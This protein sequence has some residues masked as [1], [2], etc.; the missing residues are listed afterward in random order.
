MNDYRFGNFVCF[1]REKKGMTQA[2]LAQ[3]LNVTPA[4]VSKW[5]NGSSKPRVEVLFQLAQILEVRPEE[6]IA[7]EYLEQTTL[8]PAVIEQI[9]ERYE[10]LRRI[11]SHNT[12]SVKIRRLF[13]AWIDWTLCGII[14]INF[15]AILISVFGVM[16]NEFTNSTP[17]VLF[18]LFVMLL[19][20]VSFVLRD[21]ILNGRSLG[22][23]LLKLSVLDRQ[24]GD[25]AKPSQRCCRNLLL[26]LLYVDAIVMLI[27][28]FT[29]GDRLAHTVVVSQ[30]DID[31]ARDD[32]G[33]AVCAEKI[34]QYSAPKPMSK[35]KI[36]LLLG[37]IALCF[38]MFIGFIFL[39]ANAALK[40]VRKTEEYQI[41]YTYLIES[42]TLEDMGV[43]KEQVKHVSYRLET[44]VLR[45]G[46]QHK[47]AEFG[48]DIGSKK[49]IYVVCH[50]EN[51][52]WRVC[53]ECTT[54]N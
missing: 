10:Y 16:D 44:H 22:K 42:Q 11:D 6:L 27:T 32:A 23:R 38:V 54:F 12:T 8:D 33:T 28:G 35:K 2:E 13:A 39:A 30:K 25:K 36:A 40:E 26:P 24:T 37:V 47:N 20:P 29:I 31:T 50:E 4:A 19:F 34:R 49:K 45:H 53:T 48:F 15:L 9:N 46:E 1:L 52:E 51:G 17:F 41:A 5:E 14:V 43:E 7:G 21:L 3:Q 18:L